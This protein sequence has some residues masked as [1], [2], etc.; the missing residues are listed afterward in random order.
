MMRIALP[1]IAALALAAPA[2]AQQLDPSNPDDAFRMNT[3]Q[4]CSLKEGEWAVH[5]WEGTVYSRVRGEKDRHLLDV[6][7]MS[8]RQCKPFSDP[9]KGPGSRSV[10]RE[11][12]FYMEPGTKKVLDTWKNP[13]TGE[14][15]EVVH[16]HNDPVN[17]RAPSYARNDDGTPRAEFDDFVMD[18]YAYSGGGAAL[19]F[20]DNPLAGD[21]QDYVGNK[22]QASEFLTA[23]MPM[24]DVL[25]ARATRVRDNVFSW[26]R[27]S[28]W[29][30]W[31]KMGGREG[32]LVHY[33][34]G[35]RLDS[36]D[37]L[38]QWM[39]KEVETRFPVYTTPP[40]VDDTRPNETSWTVFKKHI[41]EKR[42]AEAARPKAE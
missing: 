10:N 7:A 11:I 19:L 16:V 39:K 30:P 5:Y 25:D 31:M 13:F 37:Q 28:R 2:S 3:K 15:V 26:G 20:Y 18:G 14:D 4:F 34:G 42:A 1:L 23:V 33:M 21:Y 40:P 9:V 8:M 17:A 29:M 35:L 38:P 24:A 32:L 6:A 12:V 22:Y 27:I 41:D 36:Y